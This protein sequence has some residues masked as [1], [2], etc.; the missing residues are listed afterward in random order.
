MTHPSDAFEPGKLYKDAHRAE[1]RK[2]RVKELVAL[3]KAFDLELDG[4]NEKADI[5]ALLFDHGIH[6]GSKALHEF[7]K[8]LSDLEEI[9]RATVELKTAHANHMWTLQLVRPF[10]TEDP[11]LTQARD[12]KAATEAAIASLEAVQAKHES[13]VRMLSEGV[14]VLVPRVP[15]E[16]FGH[17]EASLKAL[18]SQDAAEKAA[19]MHKRDLLMHYEDA[20]A[21]FESKEAALTEWLNARSRT[22]EVLLRET[23]CALPA[24]LGR[25]AVS[26][27][28]CEAEIN[29]DIM[30]KRDAYAARRA[31]IA[32]RAR[33]GVIRT[34]TEATQ[35]SRDAEDLAE[36][37]IQLTQARA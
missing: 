22:M 17:L 18:A 36:L 30:S 3:A 32:S 35:L 26:L 6:A 20:P 21:A 11:W 24:A 28:K 27:S 9:D 31:K 10:W 8:L 37:E 34:S 5:E 15:A 4:L 23:A 14:Q 19:L 12:E 2:L 13:A 29:A 16:A 7:S 1:L 25:L 33:D